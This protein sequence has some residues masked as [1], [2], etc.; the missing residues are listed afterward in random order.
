MISW[1]FVVV[2]AALRFAWFRLP[3]QPTRCVAG[4]A[5]GSRLKSAAGRPSSESGRGFVG[6]VDGGAGRGSGWSGR[7]CVLSSVGPRRQS[8]TC[9]EVKRRRLRAVLIPASRRLTSRQDPDR[10]SPARPR[11]EHTPR[12]WA[13]AA[14]GPGPRGP[15]DA[16]TH[17]TLIRPTR[18]RGLC[19]GSRDLVASDEGYCT[20]SRAIVST[21]PTLENTRE[22]QKR[23]RI[24]F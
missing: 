21:I 13:W 3:T 2:W 12:R 17:I 1:V 18:I 19:A 6:A 23:P 9:R 20:V 24:S 15:V 11:R 14:P 22:F 10:A 8:G 5:G 7:V 16:E 4:R